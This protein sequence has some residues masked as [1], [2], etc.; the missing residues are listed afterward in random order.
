MFTRDD[1]VKNNM[2]C[3]KVRLG[4]RPNPKVYFFDYF[5]LLLSPVLV[6]KSLLV[7]YTTSLVTRHSVLSPTCFACYFGINTCQFANNVIKK[8]IELIKL[9]TNMISL[10]LSWVRLLQ[11]AGVSAWLSAFNSGVA[12]TG[13]CGAEGLVMFFCCAVI[14]S[15][16]CHSWGHYITAKSTGSSGP[17][18]A[19][20][21]L[22]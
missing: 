4:Y 13:K 5:L 2:T 3:T 18:G 20:I 12:A 7:Y 8:Y 9:H 1:N 14:G 10:F 22:L 19:A 17:L 11:N 6:L 21:D 16:F 15:V